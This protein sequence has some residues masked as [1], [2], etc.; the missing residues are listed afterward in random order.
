M[1]G[2]KNY[3]LFEWNLTNTEFSIFEVNIRYIGGFL[4]AFSL[5]NDR[6]FLNQAQK[7]ANFMLPVFDTPTGIPYS[8]FKDKP[9]QI[10]N[11]HH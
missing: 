3:A 1:T 6:R 5:T 9:R 2:S 10:R 4:G 8:V 7:I 11:R